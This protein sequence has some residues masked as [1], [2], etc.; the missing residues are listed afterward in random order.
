MA[1]ISP[2]IFIMLI[3]LSSACG[4]SDLSSKTPES[5]WQLDEPA[6][7]DAVSPTPE[8]L[9]QNYI[10]HPASERRHPGPWST[11]CDIPFGYTDHYP[12]DGKMKHPIIG[13]MMIIGLAP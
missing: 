5:A 3:A 10:N 7:L 12:H 8:G 6:D 4:G 11:E 9:P 2:I 1:R 13:S